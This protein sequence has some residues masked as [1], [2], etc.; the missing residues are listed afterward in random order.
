MQFVNDK[1]NPEL[2]ALNVNEEDVT[3]LQTWIN[4]INKD[5][6]ECGYTHKFELSINSN[7]V[8]LNHY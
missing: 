2:L 4:N 5:L 1:N 3:N 7:A 6:K 8:Y